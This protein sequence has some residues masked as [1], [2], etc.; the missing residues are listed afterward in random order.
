LLRNAFC[1]KRYKRGA[2]RT[3]KRN[4]RDVH[5]RANIFSAQNVRNGKTTVAEMRKRV[6]EAVGKQPSADA[7]PAVHMFTPNVL[8]EQLSTLTQR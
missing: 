7:R 4:L 1:C 3:I 6:D 5:P 2:N 8:R